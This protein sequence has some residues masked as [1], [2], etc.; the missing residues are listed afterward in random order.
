[1]TVFKYLIHTFMPLTFK[2]PWAV[3]VAV[4]MMNEYFIHRMK[5]VCY[6]ER[7]LGDAA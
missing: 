5:H 7:K 3:D 6:G 4:A 1:M 2:E